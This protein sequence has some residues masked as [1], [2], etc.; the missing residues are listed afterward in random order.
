[1]ICILYAELAWHDHCDHW[2][3][4]LLWVEDVSRLAHFPLVC[5]SRLKGGAAC[6]RTAV[7]MASKRI[8]SFW[9]CST[10]EKHVYSFS[11][12]T[13][14]EHR[15]VTEQLLTFSPSLPP[16]PPYPLLVF[17]PAP[18]LPFPSLSSFSTFFIS[19]SLTCSHL[20]LSFS[21]FLPF[22]SRLFLFLSFSLFFISLTFALDPP[23]LLQQHLLLPD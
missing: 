11:L 7:D 9:Q 5:T 10:N 13:Q 3:P 4:G 22:L 6:P 17:L 1:M 14:K 23:L 12:G 2:Q 20:I 15:L 19:S 16:L 18:R 21:F 8:S